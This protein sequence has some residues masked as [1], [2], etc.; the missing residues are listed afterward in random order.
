MNN[1]INHLVAKHGILT[2]FSIAK[3]IS[4]SDIK[5]MTNKVKKQCKEPDD[6]QRLLHEEILK[7]TKYAITNDSI[8]GLILPEGYDPDKNSKSFK[9]DEEKLIK[10]NLLSTIIAKKFAENKFTKEEICFLILNILGSLGLTDTDFK[11]F[12]EKYGKSDGNSEDVSEDENDEE[13][14]ENPS[15]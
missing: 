9:E 10:L 8:P 5:K 4:Q 15:F 2:S 14:G 12:H 1:S 7:S 13:D 3:K 11:S 6:L